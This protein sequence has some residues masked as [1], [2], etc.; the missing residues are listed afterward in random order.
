MVV[1]FQI[2]VPF[3]VLSCISYILFQVRLL[4]CFSFDLCII[5]LV[6]LNEFGNYTH[7]NINEAKQ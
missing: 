2:E 1:C 6:Y 3:L 5:Y 7:K 4:P